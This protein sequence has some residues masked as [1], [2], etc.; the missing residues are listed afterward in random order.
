MPR[1]LPDGATMIM[2]AGADGRMKQ[3]RWIIAGLLVLLAVPPAAVLAFVLIDT[4]AAANRIAGWVSSQIGREVAIDGE[5]QLELGPTLR[6]SLQGLRLA[7]APWGARPDMLSAGRLLI[8]IDSWSLLDRP[9]VIRRVEVDAF[10]LSL[11]RTPDG[12][13][14]WELDNKGR[15]FSW[16]ERPAVILERL[17]LPGA[18]IRFIGPRLARPLDLHF[19]SLAQARGTD[20][21]LVLAG[22]GSANETGFEMRASAGPVEALIAG[23]DFQLALDTRLGELTVSARASIDDLAHPA[24]SRL[25]LT[26][27]GPDAQ[28]LANRF[29]VRDLGAGPLRVD[30]S[31]VPRENGRGLAATLSGDIGAFR[32][33]ASGRLDEPQTLQDLAF[34]LEASGPDV[35]LVGGLVGVNRLPR[36]PFDLRLAVDSQ[37]ERL[38]IRDGL[39][40]LPDSRLELKGELE[41]IGK[42]EGSEVEFRLEGS[43]VA[44]FR[45]LLQLPG[46]AEGS[47]KLAGRVYRS[48]A[49]ADRL[50]IDATTALGSFSLAG[51]LSPKAD[52]QGT[53]LSFEVA[54]PSLARVGRAA[55]FA[56]LPDAQFSA[57]GKFELQAASLDFRDSMLK[58]ADNAFAWSGKVGKAPLGRDTDLRFSLKGRNLR[59]LAALT[60]RSDLPGGPYQVQGRLRRLPAASR[61]DEVR[62]QLAGASF[63]LRGR[64]ADRFMRDTDIVVAVEGPQLA[65][66]ATLLPAW[67]WPAGAFRLEGGLL[68]TAQRLELRKLRFAAG[69]ANGRVDASLAL[70]LETVRGRFDLQAQGPD[71]SR[72]LPQAGAAGKRGGDFELELRGVAD[73]GNWDISA[74]RLTSAAGSIAASGRLVRDADLLRAALS[75]EA[76]SANLAAAGQVFGVKLPAQPLEFSAQLSGIPTAFRFDQLA[77]RLGATDFRGSARFDKRERPLLDLAFESKLLDLGPFIDD[78]RASPSTGKAT[79]A[80]RLIP[81]KALPLDMLDAF[82]GSVDIRAGRVLL[83]NRDFQ[84]LRLRAHLDRGNL[85]LDALD[86]RMAPDSGVSVRGSLRR[87]SRGRAWQVDAIG[88]RMPLGIAD[89]TPERRAQRPRADFELRFTAQGESL[90]QVARTMNGRLQLVAGAG[91]LPSASTGKLFSNLRQQLRALVLP[92]QRDPGTTRIKC[93]SVVATATEGQLRTAPLLAV[94]TE[95]AS[96]ISHGTIDLATEKMEFYLKTQPADRLDI[97]LGEIINPYIKIGGTLMQPVLA[98]DPK[99]ALFSST[100]AVLTGGLSLVA[101]GTWERLFREKDPCAAALVAAER[102]AGESSAPAS[103]LQKLLRGPRRR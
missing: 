11:E 97:N 27:R 101:K 75:L 34:E 99:G 42:I 29:A 38:R 77:G 18:H 70:P 93:M 20:G 5:V 26:L 58:V 4:T 72:L 100:A 16:P 45:E 1:S 54:G 3:F 46:L 28:Y 66:F 37:G 68:L 31:V 95:D 41:R 33:K 55:D 14:N 30:A 86:L 84:D 48:P 92:Q 80:T 52:W 56:G 88:T 64:V 40:E 43:D 76:R 91:E 57:A 67:P 24:D 60:G 51:D 36:T 81:D 61:L 59:D 44:R 2:T 23:R 8:E 94:Q 87:E 62:G 22:R 21:M 50:E 63:T 71:I 69:G 17:T 6:L 85:A 25:L 32:V 49:G 89:E 74:A 39:L 102:L 10:D 53:R 35:S 19:S 15:D 90:D 103:P 65:A 83:V 79:T 73:A 98:V 78:T 7:N 47:F 82:D 96:V 12:R 13:N 9:V